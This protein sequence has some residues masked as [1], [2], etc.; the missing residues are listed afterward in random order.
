MENYLTEITSYLLTQSWQIAVLVGVIAAVSLMLKN[1][2][3]HIRYLLW[4]IVLAKCLVPPLLTVPVAVLPEQGPTAAFEPVAAHPV[5]PAV[6]PAAPV[7]V[8]PEVIAVRQMRKLTPRQWLGLGWLAG[9]GVFVLVAVAKALR[10]VFWLRRQRRPLPAELQRQVESVFS[11]L[12]VKRFP[13]LWLIDGTGQPFVWGLLR[14]SVYLPAD[15]VKVDSAQH[16]RGVLGHELSH[17]LRFDAAVNILQVIAQAI[18]W[19]HP[20][21]WWANK[22][23]RAERE[24]CCDEMAIARLGAKAKDYSSAIVNILISEYESTRP[25]PSLAVAGPVKNIEE[26]IKTMMRPGKK[27]YRRPSLIAATL[28]ILIALITVPTALVLTDRAEAEAATEHEAKSTKSLHKAVADRNI[29]LIKR[30][31]AEG[32]DINAKNE[33]A[34]TPLMWGI[35]KSALTKE[36]AELLIEKGADVNAQDDD[37]WT[38]LHGAV[39]VQIDK[40]IVRLLVSKGADVNLTTDEGWTS[41]HY[42]IVWGDIDTVKLLVDKGAKFDVKDKEGWTAL[43]R[44]ALDGRR[45]MVELFIGKGADTSSFH[46]AAFMGDLSRVKEFV[47]KGTEV[48]TKD[49]AGWTALFWA[50]SAG[51]EGVA[52]FLIDNNADISANDGSGQ[53][54]LHQAAQAHTDAHKLVELLIA[55]DADLNAKNN[56]GDTPLH[57]AC[58]SGNKEVAG[59]LIGKGA[60]I[61]AKNRDGRTPLHC[62]ASA[63]RRG[64]AELLVSKGADVNAENTISFT[65]YTPLHLAAMADADIV[66]FLID[67]GADINASS[68]SFGRTPFHQAVITGKTHN[69]ELLI[70]KG[71]DINA[72]DRVPGIAPLAWAVRQGH[73]EI[74]ELLITK[75]ADVNVHNTAG[76]TPLDMAEKRGD[77]QIVEILQKHGAKKGS[78]SLLGAVIS[79]DIEQVKLLISQ[80]ADIDAKDE[81]GR[82]PL[83]TAAKA[84]H[85]D[86]VKLLISKGADVNVRSTEELTP[87]HA[88]ARAGHLDMAKL[89]ISEGVDVSSDSQA[90][91]STPLHSAAHKGRLDMVKLLVAK[92]AKLEKKNFNGQ[93]PL[94]LAAY[95][96]RLEVADFLLAKGAEIETRTK[97]DDTPLGMAIN[98]SHTEMAELLLEK[99]ADIHA[100]QVGIPI[101]DVT[102]RKNN[103]KMVTFLVD[104]G[105]ELPTIHKAAFSGEL[106]KVKGQIGKGV[107]IDLKDAGGFTPLHCAICGRHKEVILF[108]IDNGADVN[109]R[110]ADGRFP[111]TYAETEIAELLIA[112]G[113]NVRLKDKTGQT[114]LHWAANRNDYQGD[115]ELVKLFL[116]HGADVNA[117]GYSNCVGWE[118]WTPFHVA[119]RNGNK[120]IVEMFISSGA[121]VNAKTDAG[122]TPFSLAR[123]KQRAKVV[124]LLK[125]HGAKK[126]SVT[127][128]GAVADGDIEQVKSEQT[129]FAAR[130]FNSKVAFDVWVEETSSTVGEQVGRTPSPT[131]L[132]IPACWLWGVKPLAPV[133]DWDVLVREISQNEVP[134]LRLDAADSD[135]KQLAG[136]AKLRSLNL[137]NRM[138]SKI[139]DA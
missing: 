88:A 102:I 40:D 137:S 13:K 52:E 46:M 21:V 78:S 126:G 56:S 51:R 68:G 122:D 104:K 135:L 131:P 31:I 9:V 117:K 32:A 103:A 121:D 5:E 106:D 107:Q 17:I 26:R 133:N 67:K 35:Y 22:K 12:T 74:V 34:M 58:Y 84:G 2:S 49:E 111:L 129:R 93:T 82:T 100:R 25:V 71:A 97:Y 11:G 110:T 112:K 94:Y 62:A 1:K 96:N 24:K 99:G 127:L 116:S 41:L 86:I 124:E 134:G 14:G 113:A 54:L 70:D 101:L 39:Y 92:G 33:R 95:S 6:V 10:T 7:A 72:S 55:K 50:A 128:V 47:E 119:C 65:R 120:T 43:H 28:V 18:F 90:W 123:K 76:V 63:N 80:G 27:F 64:L 30:L 4:L 132:E 75:G 83:H 48:D 77:T 138:N 36:V 108:L 105:V 20:V 23:I 91:E 85:L 81:D 66:E 115:I 57:L 60:D 136:L 109:A 61:N 98:R 118:G 29:D 114:L 125:K 89:L 37:G 16:R 8:V 69:V 79:G 130:T 139:T 87:L 38:A 45:D 73:T 59:L 44:A 15:F 3:A 53:S 42:P 19:F